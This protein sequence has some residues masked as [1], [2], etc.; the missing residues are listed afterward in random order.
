MTSTKGVVL[1]VDE[2]AESRRIIAAILGGQGY[3][4]RQAHTSEAALRSI[5]ADPPDLILLDVDLYATDGFAVDHKIR[6]DEMSRNIPL[7]FLSGSTNEDERVSWFAP[8]A[9]DFIG[10]PVRSGDLLARVATH[11]ELARLRAQL[12]N[13][14]AHQD[15]ALSAQK[16]QSIGLLAAG[17]GHDFNNMLGAIR[18]NLDLLLEDFADPSPTRQQLQRIQSTV[19]QAVEI[20]RELMIC[21]AEKVTGFKVIDLVPLAG[22]MVELLNVSISKRARLNIRFGRNLPAIRANPVQIRQVLMNLIINASEALQGDEGEIFVSLTAAPAS[23]SGKGSHDWVRLMVCD[24]GHGMPDDIRERIFEPF[25]TTKANG[26]GMG[27]SVVRGIVRAHGGSIS[28][29]SAPGNGCSFEILLPGAPRDAVSA[30][31]G[32]AARAAVGP[33]GAHSTV[34]LIEDEDTL[35]EAVTGLLRRR[36]FKVIETGDGSSAI[37]LF[38]RNQRDIGTVLLDVSLPGRSSREVLQQMRSE[39]PEVRFVLT[40][41][42]GYETAIAAVGN[43]RTPEFLRKP[44]RLQ[45]LVNLL[46]VV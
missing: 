13:G 28:V 9:V 14:V 39:R 16:L 31:D 29:T 18:A 2:D 35:R 41:A 21:A 11:L 32:I 23:V 12:E 36:G 17:I 34:L 40:S 30:G 38:R 43:Q 24:T 27:L 22:E 33:G 19:S 6:A 7:L 15:Q 1:V 5:R 45:D 44:Y 8:G 46:K 26:R 25:F 20:V 37:D 10:K 42:Y 4:V 3:R